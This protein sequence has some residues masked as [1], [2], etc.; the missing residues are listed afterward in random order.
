MGNVELIDQL[1]IAMRKY[2]GLTCKP[3]RLMRKNHLK[4]YDLSSLRKN[5]TEIVYT[6]QLYTNTGDLYYSQFLQTEILYTQ[7][8]AN[9]QMLQIWTLQKKDIYCKLMRILTENM[10]FYLYC[11]TTYFKIMKCYYVFGFFTSPKEFNLQK[12]KLFFSLRNSL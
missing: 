5:D 4:P 2:S 6:G 3:L 7:Q 10:Q 11:I 9:I 8:K 1:A 12:K